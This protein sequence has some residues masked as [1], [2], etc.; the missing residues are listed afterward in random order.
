MRQLTPAQA[1]R[2]QALRHTARLLD[3]AFQVPGTT[4]RIGIDPILGLVPGIGDLVSPLFTLG[5]LWQARDLGISRV[6]Q[7]RML[8]NVV[9][10]AVLGA[11]PLVGDLFDFAWK[12][13]EMNLALLEA[14]ATEERAPSS[15]DWFFAAG[16]TVLLLLAAA[17]PFLLTALV[18]WTL[19]SWLP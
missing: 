9:I 6:V 3:S 10:D 14:H 1:Q 12:A 11:V 18:A 17:I 2:L 15:G 13:N 19:V 7:V 16:L 8:G 5:I 4:Y